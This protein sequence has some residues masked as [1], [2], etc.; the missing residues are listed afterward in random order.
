MTWNAANRM[1]ARFMYEKQGCDLEE[2]AEKLGKTVASI[3]MVLVKM[4]VYQKVTPG[5]AE[6]KKNFKLAHSLV[7]DA[8]M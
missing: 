2:I 6:F 1:E 7:G 5:L 8:L 4:E 3:R